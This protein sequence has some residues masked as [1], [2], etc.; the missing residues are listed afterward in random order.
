MK[1]NDYELKK[2]HDISFCNERII[3]ACRQINRGDA[4]NAIINV[5]VAIRAIKD[6]PDL[7]NL[8]LEALVESDCPEFILC[9][10]DI[11]A[12]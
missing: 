1:L 11:L 7:V 5:R 6:Y 3:T 4:D 9:V 8:F 10:A 12:S 2:N